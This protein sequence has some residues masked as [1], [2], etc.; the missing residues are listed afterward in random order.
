MPLLVDMVAFLGG[1]CMIAAAF[2]VTSLARD[3]EKN[4]KRLVG[5]MDEFDKTVWNFKA[6]LSL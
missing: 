2:Y 6:K 1:V 4:N 3:V 5:V